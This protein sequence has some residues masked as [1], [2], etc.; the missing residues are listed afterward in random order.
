M[1]ATVRAIPSTEMPPVEL[2]SETNTLY[3]RSLMKN[4]E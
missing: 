3:G 2:A 1:E 4:L